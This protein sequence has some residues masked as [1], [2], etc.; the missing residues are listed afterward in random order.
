MTTPPSQPHGLLPWV[1]DDAARTRRL[2][3]MLALVLPALVLV[4]VSLAV[5]VLLSPQ[6][7]VAFGGGLGVLS[8]PAAAM[9]YRRRR[10]SGRAN[11]LG[12]PATNTVPSHATL[13]SNLSNQNAELLA[14][15][16]IEVLDDRDLAIGVEGS[17]QTPNIPDAGC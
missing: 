3:L 13:G 9:A 17:F 1:L 2:C 6:A 7:G 5:V 8:A 12:I 11:P 16:L 4:A 10:S 15:M 14:H